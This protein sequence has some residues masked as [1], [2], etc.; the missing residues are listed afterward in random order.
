M[1]TMTV[2]RMRIAR[3]FFTGLLLVTA[4][5]S[6]DRRAV[7][8]PLPSFD[9]EVESFKP[10]EPVRWQLPN[11]LTVLYLEDNELPIAKGKLFLRGGSLWVNQDRLAAISAMGDQLRQGGAGKLDA[12]Q[13]D[14][15][16]EK[17]AANVS[18]AFGSEFGSVSFNC[19]S[20][21]LDRVFEIFSDVALR[22]RFNRERIA[23]WKGQALEGIR[24]RA[25]DPSTV[26]SLS[27]TQLLYKDTPYGRVIIEPDVARV[28]SAAL[29]ALHKEF[30][31]PNGAIL[32]I[33]GRISKDKA[34]QLVNAHFGSW[35]KRENG[36]LPP[37]P[38]VPHEPL[39][40]VY[41]I[42]L[43][44]AQTT[45]QMGQLG[46]PRLTPDYPA[47]DLFNEVFGSGGFGSRLMKRIR[48]ELGLS[49][50]TYGGIAPGAVRGNN[51]IFIQTKSESTAQAIVESMKVL[52]EMQ[53]S[54]LPEAEL[55]ERKRS[56]TKSF[57]FN[58]ESPEAVIGRR[59]RLELLKFPDDFDA[60]YLPKIEMIGPP[61]VS[62]VAKN[63]WD[64]SKFVVVI[65][66]NEGALKAVEEM[67][68]NPPKVL[69]G[70]P[71][72]QATFD[73]SLILP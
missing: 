31:R 66:G 44:F 39:P 45:V 48:T 51:Y 16:L 11:G 2:F 63:R 15:E 55:E 69:Q 64:L 12:D 24:R 32:V 7:E 17:L 23:L 3:S 13:L 58:F 25:E 5:C 19:L 71:F 41:F 8:P 42:K 53:N 61:A 54:P 9:H 10:V 49:Y 59:A 37:P 72:T 30:V 4:G 50:G 40:G 22:P 57:I 65:V 47:I 67:M 29:H 56:I 20:D 21:D 6:W 34:T 26:A 35:A 18:S 28:D 14:L 60:T 1:P 36:D 46:V 68:K 27:Y 70:M 38:P 73:S 33:T 52:G 43:P 62:D